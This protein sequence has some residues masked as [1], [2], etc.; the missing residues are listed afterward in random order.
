MEIFLKKIITILILIFC[1]VHNANSSSYIAAKLLDNNNS[2]FLSSTSHSRKEYWSYSN[3]LI[4][5]K[6]IPKDIILLN[7][8]SF[9][10]SD[11][12]TLNYINNLEYSPAKE[13]NKAVNANQFLLYNESKG[14]FNDSNNGISKKFEKKY[15][16][17]NTLISSNKLNDVKLLLSELFENEVKNLTEQCLYAWLASNYFYKNK[18]TIQY[19]SH[20]ETA[21]L[22][23]GQVPTKLAY[24]I[25]TSFLKYKLYY[26]EYAKAIEI[27]AMMKSIE[28]LKLDQSSYKQ[29]FDDVFKMAQ[30]SPVITHEKTISSFG[31]SYHQLSRNNISLQVK[32]DITRA[33]LRCRNGFHIFE[34]TSFDNYT[35]PKNL[36]K[37]SLFLIGE[38]NASATLTEN[39]ALNL[40]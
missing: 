27:L 2:K 24:K 23:R 26:K 28:G 34:N 33:E 14:F 31:N 25:S 38:P 1:S 21:Y 7:T 13:D 5:I 37:C 9:R 35:I 15:H 10:K 6:G 3:Y 36:Q 19:S 40:L 11:K 4:D 17:I 8:T 32:S 12:K 22:L 39:G 30:E 29:A 18:D 16:H 20:L